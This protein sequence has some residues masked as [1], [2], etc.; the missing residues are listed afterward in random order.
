MS[1]SLKFSGRRCGKT[2]VRRLLSTVPETA[3]SRVIPTQPVCSPPDELKNNPEA[4]RDFVSSGSSVPL[5]FKHVP[6]QH[7]SRAETLIRALRKG[8]D[9][10]VDIEVGRYG[11][12][13]FDH[14]PMRL[15]QYLDWLESD[16]RTNG[17]VGGHQLYLAQW[18]GNDEV[19]TR[20][21]STITFLLNTSVK[22]SY[23][24]LRNWSSRPRFLR[25]FCLAV[26][27]I[28][29]R[30]AFSLV[31]VMR[32]V[33]VMEPLIRSHKRLCKRSLRSI[34]TPTRTST[35]CM[36]HQRPPDVQN[37]SRC[38]HHRLPNSSDA[39]T[40]TSRSIIPHFSTSAS[41]PPIQARRI[42]RRPSMCWS[43]VRP[44]RIQ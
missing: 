1:L 30:L 25:L 32:Y 13:Q 29:T 22:Y 15:G 20:Y 6:S 8:E 5:H 16:E 36:P 24:R 11:I 2:S 23:R 21:Y 42:M 7:D 14:V 9:R 17:T 33:E 39:Q 4:F 12:G 18:R 40:H 43:I 31:L 26:L 44:L 35:I 38:C 37:I 27:P 10:L 28:F 41:D 19:R 34:T 3:A